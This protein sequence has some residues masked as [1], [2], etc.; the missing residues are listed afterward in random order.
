MKLLALV[1]SPD[2]VCCRY[3]IRA[4]TPALN[5]AGWELILQPLARGPLQRVRQLSAVGSYDAVILQRKLLPR[6][7]LALLRQGA[8]RLIFDFDD[9]VLYRDSFDPRG[10]KSKARSVRFSAVVRAAD[11]VIAGNDFLAD[12][13]LRSGAPAECVRMI[14]TCVEP[15]HYPP[16]EGLRS[17]RSEA[18]SIDLVWIG[19]SSTLQGLEQVATLWDRIGS[20]IPRVRLKVICDRFPRFSKIPVVGIPWSPESEV[21]EL[22][23]SQIGIS[24]MPDDLWS[25][26]KCGL[27]VLQYQAASLPVVANP[28][29]SHLELIEAGITGFLPSTPEAWVDSIRNLATRSGLRRRM[30]AIA[31]ERVEVGYSVHAWAETF[32]GAISGLERNATAISWPTPP[33]RPSSIPRPLLARRPNAYQ[34]SPATIAIRNSTHLDL[35]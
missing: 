31:R 5:R 1:D 6:W 23:R 4:F 27:K 7:Q 21:Q 35:I 26:G 3:R 12:C 15:G 29:G 34:T 14:P 13:A 33:G 19:S 30:G 32:V 9:A 11:V 8:K 17:H 22:S 10:L 25:R 2:H 24:W 18:E 20:E 28:V 16:P